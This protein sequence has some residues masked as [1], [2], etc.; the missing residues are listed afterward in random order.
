MEIVSGIEDFKKCSEIAKEKGKWQA[1]YENYFVKYKVFDLILKYLYMG[2]ISVM[3]EGVESLDFEKAIKTGGKFQDDDGIKLVKDLLLKCEEFC[4]I[5]IDY[6]VYLLIGSGLCDG[7]SLPAKDPFLY[8]GLE[9]YH[10]PRQLRY[11][12]PHEYNHLVRDS[13]VKDADFD[14]IAIKNMVISEGLATLFPVL[15][16]KRE[17]TPLSIADCGMMP[18]DAARYCHEHEEELF[19]EIR[20]IWGEKPTP[21]LLTEYFWSSSEGWRDKIQKKGYYAG[22]RIIGSLLDRGH[23]ICSL[24]RMETDKILKLWGE[25]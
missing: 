9:F 23:D 11:L 4:S 1:W 19:S 24:T 21:E 7:T 18:M 8:F 25:S 2:D 20:E 17:I 12:I 16:E 5:D 10:S 15:L 6:A 22:S 3:K 13:A 14:K